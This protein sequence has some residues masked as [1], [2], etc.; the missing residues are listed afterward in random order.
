METACCAIFF[1]NQASFFKNPV[2]SV[3]IATEIFVLRK[4]G[5]HRNDVKWT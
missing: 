1:E 5:F 4:M 2:K 3:K